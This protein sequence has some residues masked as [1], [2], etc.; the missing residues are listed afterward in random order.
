MKLA[1]FGRDEE[2]KGEGAS[3]TDEIIN[4][5]PERFAKVTTNEQTEQ[6]LRDELARDQ[7]KRR[8]QDHKNYK[9]DGFFGNFVSLVFTFCHP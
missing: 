7:G 5:N 6:K 9:K 2:N 1:K 4:Q 8:P 3:V